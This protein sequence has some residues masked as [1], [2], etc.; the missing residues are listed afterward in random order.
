M[1]TEPMRLGHHLAT[2]QNSANELF[3]SA[4]SSWEIS[5]KY[6]LGRLPLPSPPAEYVPER[7]RS[8]GVTPLPVS[9]S[10]TYAVATLPPHHRDPFDRLLIA[11]ALNRELTLLTADPHFRDYEVSI[12]V[13]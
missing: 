8:T 5:I 4:A 13:A 3:L 1:L 10:D 11:Q 12:L 7:I 9:H 2:V 6:A